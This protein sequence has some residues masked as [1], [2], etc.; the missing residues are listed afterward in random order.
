M[1]IG[2]VGSG[3]I[4]G[5]HLWAASRYPG[6]EIV[7]IADRDLSR[8][9]SQA[10]LFNVSRTFA[11]LTELLELKPDVVH[12]LTPPAS[13][14]P[15]AVQALQAG[16]HVYVEK[17]MALTVEDCALMTQAAAAAGRQLCVGHCW[18][19]SP[20]MLRATQ[21]IESGVT[22]QVLQ[23]ASS[24]NFDVRR[25]A[26]YGQ[27]H[28]AGDLPGGLAE[29]LAIH[30][31]SV[32]IRLLGAP[33]KTTAATRSAPMI[34]GGGTADVRALIDAEHGLGTLSVSLRGKPDMG[35]VEI[36][37]EKML[38]RL[39]ISSM[40]V[41]MQRELPVPQ[42]IGRGL[43]N[44]DV[45]TQLITSTAGTVWKM[46]RKKVDGSYGIAPLIHAFYDAIKA[47]KPAPV[48]PLEGTQSIAMMRAIWPQRDHAEAPKIATV[49]GRELMSSAT[50]A[51]TGQ[52]R[53]LVT[54][55][56]GFVGSHLVRELLRRGYA[57]R[58]LARNPAKAA[59][60]A[61]AGAQ[62]CLGDLGD[63]GTIEGIAQ[64]TDVIFHLGSAMYGDAE[65]F[66]RI[67]VQGTGQ[68]LQEAQRAGARRIV[69]AGTL[70]SYPLA[71]QRSGAVID[72]S[73]PFDQSGQL[74]H[75]A[76]AK[77]QAE[78]LIQEAVRSGALE[79]VI[80]RLGLVCGEGAGIYPPHVCQKVGPNLVVMYGNGR[81]P[82]PLTFIDNA[83]EALIL[84]AEVAGISGESFNIVDDDVLTQ[85]QYLDLL[86]RATGGA[87]R[88]LRM[89]RTAYYALG[90]LTEIAA[91]A[92]KK[93]PATTRY[94]IRNRITPVRW[95][96]SKAH[97]VLNWRPR[98]ALADG[99]SRAFS[100]YAA[101]GAAL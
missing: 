9:R 37:C 46:L 90:L 2:I 24:F 42:K 3:M 22:G 43:G 65:R 72:E 50:A 66:E 21:L 48:G 11:S 28:W 53:A 76:R 63:A 74:G 23:A 47:G 83:V 6:A 38:L 62:V 87:P 79:G 15:L 86:R 14:A 89:P 61:Q 56:T 57:V 71:R 70:A 20:A 94:R 88:V 30:P 55:A 29:D 77:V 75:Y 13:H 69:F 67:D 32:L 39:N 100:A 41:T 82:L 36:V 92:R 17:P 27:G 19:Y 18:L 35:Q 59:S 58:V 49:S 60:L 40:T 7:G 52:K 5:H 31:A 64:G 4:S 93:E 80:V 95:D 51:L 91:A 33:L 26:S 101:S 99:L 96:C 25:N 8:A 10:A 34:P 12:I 81:V 45:A 84:G 1:K 98:V 78:G 44:V 73:C 68:L 54:G 85:Q 97:R 16:A